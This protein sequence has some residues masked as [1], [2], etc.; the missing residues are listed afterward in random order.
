MAL[1]NQVS[2]YHLLYGGRQL[3]YMHIYICYHSLN[4]TVLKPYCKIFVHFYV[5]SKHCVQHYTIPFPIFTTFHSVTWGLGTV[6]SS[7]TE[8]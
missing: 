6:G 3:L 5:A 4:I 2:D 7:E 1:S 8:M